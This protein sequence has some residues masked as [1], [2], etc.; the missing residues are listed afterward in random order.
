MK[1]YILFNI[2]LLTLCTTTLGRNIQY[3]NNK[4]EEIKTK[5]SES[6]DECSYINSLLGKD[7]TYNC[8]EENGITCEN[9]FI[10]NM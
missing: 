2:F 9:G 5:R 3:I 7:E 8:C 6:S 4:F 1:I 10:V